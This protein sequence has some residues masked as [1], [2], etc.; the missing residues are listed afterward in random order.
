MPTFELEHSECGQLMNVLANATGPNIN[1]AVVN[2]L[3]MK[4]GEQLR[5]QQP[6]LGDQK[7]DPTS[8]PKQG[9]GPE[10][11]KQP[12]IRGNRDATANKETGHG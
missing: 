4:I 8:K 6:A 12:P 5:M 7:T 1:W 10:G 2:P 9:F 11:P 3:L